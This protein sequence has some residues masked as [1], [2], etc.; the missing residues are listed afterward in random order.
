MWESSAA[1]N[2][3]SVALTWTVDYGG[4][5]KGGQD[6]DR[7]HSPGRV[8]AKRIDR[9]VWPR[10]SDLKPDAGFLDCPPPGRRCMPLRPLASTGAEQPQ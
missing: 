10:P 7:R 2:T 1:V 6:I 4:A 5:R 8:N 9:G 3:I